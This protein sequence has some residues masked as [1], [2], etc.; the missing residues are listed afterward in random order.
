METKLFCMVTS[1]NDVVNC[2]L[3][4]ISYFS[5]YLIPSL[6]NIALSWAEAQM[7]YLTSEETRLFLYTIDGLVEIKLSKKLQL[8]TYLQSISIFLR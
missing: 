5:W 3:S 1:T 6:K 4:S 2:I 8:P 7:F